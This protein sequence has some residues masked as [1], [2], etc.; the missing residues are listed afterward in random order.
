MKMTK[1][2]PSPKK[3]DDLALTGGGAVPHAGACATKKCD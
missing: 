3:G 2:S 1:V